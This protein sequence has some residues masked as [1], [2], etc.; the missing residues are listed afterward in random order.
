M[1]R[2][3]LALLRTLA[4]RLRGRGLSVELDGDSLYAEHC[5]RRLLVAH[6]LRDGRVRIAAVLVWDGHSHVVAPGCDSRSVTPGSRHADPIALAAVVRSYL[7]AREKALATC[8]HRPSED[9]RCPECGQ[10]LPV[11]PVGTHGALFSAAAEMARRGVRG[12]F[13]TEARGQGLRVVWCTS[14]GSRTDITD[15]ALAC[16]VAHLRAAGLSAD[17][18]P[19]A[20][21]A[22]LSVLP[23]AEERTVLDGGESEPDASTERECELYQAAE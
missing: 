20:G 7:A 1:L 13:R 22:A 6:A 3:A 8:P 17:V 12:S 23:A 18:V 14:E 10:V 4:D 9:R 21:W 15:E 5:G 16:A 19:R 11:A 2:D